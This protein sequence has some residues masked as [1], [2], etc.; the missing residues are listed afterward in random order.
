ML[1]LLGEH[2]LERGNLEAARSYLLSSIEKNKKEAK[3][4]LSYVRLNEAIFTEK[5]DDKSIQN[6]LRGYLCSVSLSQYKARLI[7]PSFLRLLK[8]RQIQ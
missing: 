2:M 4:W 1:R 5:R 7:L 6:A 8:T 3:T